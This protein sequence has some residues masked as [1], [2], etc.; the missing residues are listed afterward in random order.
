MTLLLIFLSHFLAAPA[1]VAG[2]VL[3]GGSFAIE[4]PTM[5]G[6]SA[7]LTGGGFHLQATLGQPDAEEPLAAGEFELR[8]GFW[9]ETAAGGPPPEDIFS[10]GFE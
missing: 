2:P 9:A 1:P 7:V 10:D 5:D 4:R 3:A 8:G 6:G